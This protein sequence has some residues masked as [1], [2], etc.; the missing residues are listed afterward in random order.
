METIYRIAYEFPLLSKGKVTGDKQLPS[1][2]HAVLFNDDL[3][4]E[5]LLSSSHDKL[6]HVYNP[7]IHLFTTLPQP[8]IRHLMF[9]TT[10]GGI[11]LAFDPTKLPHYKVIHAGRIYGDDD[12]VHIQIQTYFSGSRDWII[13]GGLYP[14]EDFECFDN[15][16]Y[17]NGAI[18]WL[19]DVNRIPLYSKLDIVDHPVLTTM[20]LKLPLTFNGV[21]HCNVK[22]FESCG[23]LLLLYW[24]YTQPRQLNIYEMRNGHSEWP[25]KYLVNLND[26]MNLFPKTWDICPTVCFI[27]LGEREEDSFMVMQLFGKL[28]QYKIVLKTV[29][30][31]CNLGSASVL[32]RL[33]VMASFAGV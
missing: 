4:L 13:C 33:T 23:C 19:K 5:I 22:L 9:D 14:F 3:L 30:T 24:D 26:I 11:K 2:V 21:L 8:H 17:W 7:S 20:F 18:H 31:H 10:Y 12:E 28:V 27:A 32:E 1:S 6:Y 25:V 16:I 29:H 15:E